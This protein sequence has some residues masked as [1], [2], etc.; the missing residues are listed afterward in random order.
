MKIM[1]I[2]FSRV[3]HKSSK[4]RAKGHPPIPENLNEWPENWKAC[5]YK[6]YPRYPKIQLQD[7]KPRADFFELI[8]KRSSNH[9]YSKQP[10]S[11][12]ELS[13]LLQ[14]SCG[15]T[16]L[17]NN[18]MLRRAQPSG[19]GLFPIE[20]YPLVVISGNDLLSGLYHYNVQNHQLDVLW[21]RTFDH[22]FIKGLFPADWMQNAS[23]IFI[24]TAV[25]ERNQVKYGERGYRYTLL[26]A[27]HI[28]QNIYLNAEA[29]NLQCCALGFTEDMKIESLLEI[30]GVTESVVYALVVGK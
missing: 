18:G 22:K 20:V 28:G 27:G 30:D 9:Q 10:I 7:V 15:V 6:T 19:G 25:F 2:D 11:L 3:F 4:N 5:S 8:L 17:A 12:C 23:L 24:L 14:Y 16:H 26:E 21:N 1:D 29:L 13:I